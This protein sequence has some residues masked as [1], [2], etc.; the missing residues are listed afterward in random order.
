MKNYIDLL[1][2]YTQGKTTLEEEQKLLSWLRNQENSPELE[3]YFLQK[4]ET[5]SDEQTM[6]LQ[7]RMYDAI[8]N[9][10]EPEVQ[11]QKNL[12]RKLN[13]KLMFRWVVAAC[14]ILLAV[15]GGR[16][17]N[18]Y[19]FKS[20]SKQ[21]ILV[22]KGQRAHTKMCIR[23]RMISPIGGLSALPMIMKRVRECLLP[24]M[25]VR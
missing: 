9:K 19:E 24:S 12:G 22:E 15:F 25:K 5:T 8:C 13:Y 7:L 11:E 23:D 18:I 17:Y 6:E 14:I 2:R 1:E 4:W 20:R 3:K 21:T 16:Y 10:L